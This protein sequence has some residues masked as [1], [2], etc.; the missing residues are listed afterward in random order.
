[1]VDAASATSRI[2]AGGRSGVRGLVA[3]FAVTQT[4]GY[5]VLYYAFSVLLVPIATDLRASPAAI[6]GALTTSVLVAAGAAIPV[7]RWL[8]R[9]GGRRL[10]TAGSVL[11][12]I[13]VLAWSQ[14]ETVWQL[15]AVFVLIGL[16]S[17]MSLYEAAF[18]VLVAVAEPARRAG[19][20]VGVTLVAGFASSLFFPLTAVLVDRLGWRT[21]VAVLAALLAAIAVPGHALAVPERPGHAP[22]RPPHRPDVRRALADREFWLLTV[23]FVAH[24]GAMATMAVHLV[25]FLVSA[26]HT[27]TLAATLSGLLGVLSVT[28]RL[29]TTGLARRYSIS[30]VTAVI[31]GV[32][33]VGAASLPT[34]GTSVVGAA[35]G[36]IAF[37]LGFGVATIARPAV[38]ADRYTVGGYATI[39]A[40]MATPVTIVKAVAPLAAATLPPGVAVQAAGAACLLSG[41]FL[42]AA[43]Q[44]RPGHR[45]RGHRHAQEELGPPV[46][47]GRLPVV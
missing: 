28:G 19:A 5:G 37:G 16:A 4:V 7:G 47:S 18:S 6:T 24:A 23:G 31:F 21:A 12:S 30:A 15:Y 34:L 8:D 1:M 20:L 32:Q 22:I 27:V 39:A 45:G 3:M 13:A 2:R 25:R 40:T 36:V 11:G 44:A 14:V 41:A 9:R 17:A 42:L 29:V 35:A 10:M 46:V 43:R 33:A 26:G 38:L